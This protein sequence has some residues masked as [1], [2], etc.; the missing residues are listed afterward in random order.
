MITR[1]GRTWPGS[2]LGRARERASAT[3]WLRA[4]F[5]SERLTEHEAQR[6]RAA[7]LATILRYS[8]VMMVAN[9]FNAVVL[10]A[11]LSLRAPSPAPYLWMTILAL[12]LM[13]VAKSARRRRMFASQAAPSQSRVRKA[14]AYAGTLGLIWAA[15]PLLFLDAARSDQLIVICVCVGMLC[16]GC[17]VL[18]TLPAAVIAFTLPIA[19]GTLI[20]LVRNAHDPIHYLTVLLLFSYAATL[21][22]AAVAHG[23]QHADRVI[24]QA[25]AE[26]AA[27]H[28]ALTGL[29]NRAAFETA[30]NQAFA[31]LERRG[32]RFAL[33]YFDLDDFK[34]VND[35]LGHYAGDQLLQQVAGRLTVGLRAR[36]I[37]ARLGG[38]EFVLL[39][40]SVSTQAMRSGARTRLR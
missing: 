10:I 15:V 6:L 40:A 25:Q 8:P 21:S 23:L 32:E 29:P 35:R 22:A 27:R 24:A 4:F 18:A 16:G 30:L 37:V 5:H 31:R 34:R 2:L 38:D 36:D 39:A 17:F 7:Q 11:A 28:D 19:I 14:I 13:R 3:P 12:Y 9:A 20:A 1:L 33:L 26:K